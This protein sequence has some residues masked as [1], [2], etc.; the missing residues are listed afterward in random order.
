MR[1]FSIPYGQSQLLLK[2][3]EE[4]IACVL[5]PHEHENPNAALP[6]Q[7][8]IVQ[9]A[10]EHPI[11]TERLREKVRGK[12]R[13]LVITS[14]HTRP[15]PS[16]ITLPILLREIRQGAPDAEVQILIATGM[17][18]PT[19]QA[20]MIGKFGAELVSR[21]TFVVHRA[22]QDDQMCFKGILPSGGELWLNKLVDWADITV[23]E[24]FVEPHFFAGFSG[25]RKSVLP[26]IASKKTVLYNHN[27]LF[28]ADKHASTGNLSGNPIHRDMVFAAKQAGL[29][30]ILNV[31]LDANKRIVAAYAGDMEAAHQAGCADCLSRTGATGVEADIAVTSNGGYPLDQNV[32]QSVKGMTAAEACVRPG[33]VIVMCA[34]LG[35][36]H[37]G[38][39]FYRWFA[40]RENADAVAQAIC[41]VSP[42]NTRMDQWEAQILARIQ[43]KAHCI[44]VTGPEN[45]QLVQDMHMTWAGSL[46]DAMAIAE[47][48]TSKTAS[49]AVIPDGVGVVVRRQ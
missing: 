2:L 31:L 18:R 38:E 8:E 29:A 43:Q 23:S 1:E 34:A 37:G 26:G 15:V 47:E 25:G 49:V 45:R 28:I 24:G 35:D 16:A 9:K 33:G 4:R 42:E 41:G 3:P 12:R 10:L 40:D 11:G 44:F 19:T 13:V 46:E 27:A 48:L 7:A 6:E 21:E 39:D 14:D 5:V 22:N 36:G 30:F 32:Y 17:H 20:E